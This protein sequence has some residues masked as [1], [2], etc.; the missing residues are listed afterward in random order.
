VWGAGETAAQEYSGKL[1]GRLT[2]TAGSILPAAQ[3]LL[4]GTALGA[5][6]DVNGFYFINNV[7]VGIYTVRAQLIG[8]A[9][10]EARGIQIQGG[11]TTDLNVILQESAIAVTGVTVMGAGA[12][13]PRD[14]VASKTIVTGELIRNL[15]VDQLLNIVTLQPGV[16]ELG[17]QDG[18]S[19]RGSRP[20]E[21]QTYIDGAPVRP[22]ASSF[23][24]RNGVAA[25]NRSERQ[26]PEVPTIG[27]E[28]VTVTTGALAPSQGNAQAGAITYTTRAGGER[29][30]GS[31]SWETDEPFANTIS[32]GLNRFEGALGGP[33]PGIPRLRYF[34]SGALQGAR[35]SG[36]EVRIGG[37][38]FRAQGLAAGWDQVPTYIPGA[39]DTT[40]VYPIDATTTRSIIIP[41]FIQTTG[42]CGSL[43]SNAT[44]VSRAIQRNYG[45][46]CQGA[47]LPMNWR[48]DAQLQSK[49][50]YSYGLGSTVSI[51]GLANG[52]QR[53]L[54]PAL[55]ILDPALFQ[56]EHRWSRAAILNLSHQ[57]F[58]RTSQSLAINLNASWQ[59]DQLFAGPLTPEYE[60]SSRSPAL[61]I[62]LGS[63]RFSGLDAIQYPV[64]HQLVLAQLG[65]LG[66]VVPYEGRDDL[67]N[68]QEFR[69]NPMGV[70]T[71]GWYSRGMEQDAQMHW[72]RR[73]T[74]QLAVDWQANRLHRLTFGGEGLW[75]TVA[76]WE[77][78]NLTNRSTAGMYRE[79][80]VV[81]AL[82]GS[83]RLDLGD[84]VLELGVRW[85]YFHTH[86]RFPNRFVYEPLVHNT[87]DSIAAWYTRTTIPGVGH[88]ALSPR[89]RVSFP[90]AEHTDLRLSFGRQVQVPEF[91]FTF[92]NNDVTFGQTIMYEFGMR[93]AL[94]PQAILDVA[95]YNKDIRSE[96]SLRRT[97]F[98]NP[99]N[100]GQFT[101]PPVVLNLD[102]GHA[103]GGEIRLDLRPGSGLQATVSYAYQTS[104]STGSDPLAV[105]YGTISQI[106]NIDSVS[107][108]QSLS[109]ADFDRTHTGLATVTW[110]VP[111]GS[112][113]A[114]LGGGILKDVAVFATARY[115]SGLPYTS[116]DRSGRRLPLH[117]DAR[118]PPVANV[119]ARVTK[120]FTRGRLAAVAYLDVRNVLNFRTVSAINPV[121]RTIDDSIGREGSIANELL[122]LHGEAE[123]NGQTDPSH[124]DVSHCFTW[125]Q[126]PVDC[127]ALS[128]TEARYG[129][130]DGWFTLD[131]QR[132]AFLAAY[133]LLNGPQWFYRPP[134]R[135]RIGVEVS[136]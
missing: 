125:P 21:V 114:R 37:G 111:R 7:P 127:A 85:D 90:V 10:A 56:G 38:F 15:P 129:N 132:R 50:L 130:G 73:Y 72:E 32:Q 6:T 75:T 63:I 112:A 101:F 64:T 66:V 117:N 105:F 49:L 88:A 34:V 46:A 2:S 18:F 51:T 122:V 93:Q 31:F 136:F 91:F 17:G 131:E 44:A 1:Q 109:V 61:G 11:Q 8:Y 53:R 98:P 4:L 77:A 67:R 76:H 71:S 96:L 78:G 65:N 62:E 39:P 12:G 103:R 79:S 43:G 28:E 19:L 110:S 33:V 134:R 104:R 86:S 26:T 89:V 60:L 25:G 124:I 55:N 41:T 59:R 24:I 80:P 48:T 81:Y 126:D 94:S 116:Q 36:A 97:R 118:Q 58:R 92:G 69:I 107:P 9:P 83:E 29:A 133:T 135:V 108:A 95:L 13:A 5:V 16:V 22:V 52:T 23:R 54:W 14:E 99:R 113:L 47:R 82:F 106:F 42:V 119:D 40:V 102:F 121:T 123:V 20:G 45:F 3:V 68:S 87:V 74:A 30:S 115:Q 70:A 84:F 35:S 57:V 128:R 100:P 27:A 120:T